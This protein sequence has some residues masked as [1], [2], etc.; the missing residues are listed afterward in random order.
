MI[1]FGA[2]NYFVSYN[3]FVPY[4]LLLRNI[5]NLNH[6]IRVFFLICTDEQ[7]APK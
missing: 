7:C 5:E 3:S 6:L 4:F 1:F 2:I